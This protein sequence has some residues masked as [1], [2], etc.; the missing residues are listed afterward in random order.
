MEHV[1]VGRWRRKKT[2]HRIEEEIVRPL[3]ASRVIGPVRVKI[4]TI[5]CYVRPLAIDGRDAPV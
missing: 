5:K 4:V 3:S 2:E 1:R